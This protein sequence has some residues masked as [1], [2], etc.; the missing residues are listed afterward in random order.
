MKIAHFQV[1]LELSSS[2]FLVARKNKLYIY[3]KIKGDCSY[4]GKLPLTFLQNILINFKITARL[5]RL[6]NIVCCPFN[7]DEVLLGFNHS[8]YN[9]DLKNKVISY[10]Y[11]VDKGK[12]PLYFENVMDNEIVPEGIYFGDYFGNSARKEVAIYRIDKVNKRKEIVYTFKEG[13]IN[14]VHSLKIDYNNNCIWIFTGDFDRAAAIWQVKKKFEIVQPVV[15]GKQ[16]YR[17]CVASCDNSSVVYATDTPFQQNY[18]RK[19]VMED[20]V[21]RSREIAKVNGSVIYGCQINDSLI[22]STAVEPNGIYKNRI[23]ALFSRKRGNGI[24]DDYCYVYLY[25]FKDSSLKII[26]KSKKD[27]LPYAT[28]QFGALVFPNLNG[29]KISELPIFHLAT[30]KYDLETIFLKL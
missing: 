5:F 20:G 16:I 26:Y 22:F 7:Q 9:I 23:H 27:R 4:I 3:D 14:H 29:H 6:V 17:A 18:L 24:A 25:S 19:L 11:S 28:F 21:W 8:F 1:L 10:L 15:R 2:K 13:M 30:N 12:R